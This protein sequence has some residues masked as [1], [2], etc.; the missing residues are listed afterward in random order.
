MM[1]AHLTIFL[2]AINEILLVLL[3]GLLPRW[4]QCF[5]LGDVWNVGGFLQ[6]EVINLQNQDLHVIF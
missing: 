4:G 5:I 2:I 6:S 3:F 1:D